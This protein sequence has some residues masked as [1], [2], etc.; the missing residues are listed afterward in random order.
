MKILWLCNI[1]LPELCENFGLKK[2]NAGGWLT[3]MWQELKKIENIELGICVPIIDKFRRKDGQKDNYLYFSFPYQREKNISEEQ[4]KRFE[5]IL[6]EF[7]PDII[8]IWGTEY[9]HTWAMVQACKKKNLQERIV[10]NIQGLLTYCYPIYDFGLPE[11]VIFD[12]SYGK[13]IHEEKLDFKNRSKFEVLALQNV[14]HVVG[15]TN[16]DRCCVMRISGAYYHKCGEILREIFY[17]KKQRWDVDKCERHSIFI[18]QAG[19]PIKGFHLALESL[20]R[21]KEKYPDLKV[22][23]AGADLHIVETSYAHYICDEIK[24]Y[25]LEDTVY[26]TGQL[27]DVEMYEC[28]LKANVF[29]SLS[30]EENSPNSVCEAMSVGTPV[31]AS[32]VGGISSMLTHKTSGFLYPLTES[33]MMEYYVRKIFEDD[34]LAGYLSDNVKGVSLQFNNKDVIVKEMTNIYFKIENRN[35]VK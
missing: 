24:K 6:E 17:E 14:S 21:L 1:V 8:H 9:H 32:Y 31:V 2:T 19:Y 28:Y 13:T 27:S 30:T 15:R 35:E 26:F 18:S 3:G 12:N 33:Y 22:F 10:I 34:V 5:E 29:L 20:F 23:V 11:D 25:K 16:W 7:T 4:K